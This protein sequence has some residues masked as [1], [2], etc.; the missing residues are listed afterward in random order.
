MSQA[1]IKDNVLYVY[2]DLHTFSTAFFF[3]LTEMLS[4]AYTYIAHK[5]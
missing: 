4:V 2:V 1:E 3:L 5:R